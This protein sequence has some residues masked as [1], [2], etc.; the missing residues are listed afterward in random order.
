MWRPGETVAVVSDAG[1]PSVSDP[2][3]RLVAAAAAAGVEV[4]AVPGPSAVLAAL[5][6]SG[7]PPAASA[8]RASSPAGEAIVVGGSRRWPPRSAPC[9]LYE[10][11]GRLAATLGGPRRRLRTRTGP[12]SWPGS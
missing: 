3:A 8:S 11:P 9:V 12:W 1:T 6:V 2:G 5:V 7:L 4:T 10:A